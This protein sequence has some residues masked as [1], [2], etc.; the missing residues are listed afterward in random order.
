DGERLALEQHPQRVDGT[1]AVAGEDTAHAVDR[2]EEIHGGGPRG[3][4]AP[5]QSLEVARQ[6]GPAERPRAERNAHRGGDADRGR[7]PHDHVLDGARDVAVRAVDAVDLARREEALVDHDDAAVPP[8]D[9][10]D[11]HLARAYPNRPSR[12]NAARP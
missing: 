2:P 5:A 6:V 9:R 7:A 12:N 4:E 10:P 3:G 11:W 8:L 1:V